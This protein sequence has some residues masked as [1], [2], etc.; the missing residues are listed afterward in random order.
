MYDYV[1]NK[2]KDFLMNMRSVCSDLINQLVQ[3]INSEDT[4]YVEA[5]LV[6]S[7]A[8]HLETQ[9]NNEPIDLDYNLVILDTNGLNIN[10][11]REI[12][13]YV[14]NSFNVVLKN[15]GWG[16]CK[17]STSALS[18]ERRHFKQGNKTEFSI[19]LA[20]ITEDRESWYRL[21]HEKTGFVNNDRYYWNE[22]PDSKGLTKRVEWIKKNDLWNEVRDAY[23]NKKN[24]YLKRGDHNHPS[25][26]VYIEAVNEVYYSNK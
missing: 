26:N 23:L 2:D 14:R 5:N 20:I 22:G 13:K 4:L 3:L 18:T 16:D 1:R 17:D 21:I 10:D 19:D 12:K 8:K 25:F 6:G 24:L 11:C 15:N 9:N 7:G